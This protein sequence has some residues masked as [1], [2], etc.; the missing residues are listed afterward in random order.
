MT[1][2]FQLSEGFVAQLHTASNAASVAIKDPVV[3]ILN[4]RK[5]S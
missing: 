2:Q 4:V 5:I 1:A 3:Q